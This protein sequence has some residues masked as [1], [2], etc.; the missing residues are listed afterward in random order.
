MNVTVLMPGPTDTPALHRLGIKNP[1][2]KPMRVERCVSEALRALD[3][4]RATVVPGR[5]IRWI[6]AL[7]PASVARN[8]T[9]RMFELALSSSDASQEKPR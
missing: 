8:Q 7:I 5:L 6:Y 9:A 1:P 2:M 3:A 4:N